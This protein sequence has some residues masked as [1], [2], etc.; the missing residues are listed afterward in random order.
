M[1]DEVVCIVTYVNF[2]L[3]RHKQVGN[4]HNHRDVVERKKL[5]RVS[6]QQISEQGKEKADSSELSNAL[7]VSIEVY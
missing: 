5:F 4:C 6:V 3:L 2:C 1:L 7:S